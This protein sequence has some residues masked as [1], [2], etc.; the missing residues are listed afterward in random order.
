[1]SRNKRYEEKKRSEGLSKI[2]I[3]VSSAHVD[4][5]KLAASLMCSDSN[6]T[7][8]SLRDLRSNRFVSLNARR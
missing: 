2:T 7:I 1:M 8:G 4:D 6:L 5:I 3:W